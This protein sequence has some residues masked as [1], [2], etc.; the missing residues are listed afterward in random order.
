MANR[1]LINA[2]KLA[3]R[4]M[5]RA[6]QDEW[7]KSRPK[8][9]PIQSSRESLYTPRQMEVRGAVLALRE[10]RG[11]KPVMIDGP[12]GTGKT[13]GILLWIYFLMD[14]YPGIRV[15]IT[16]KTK[17]DIRDSVLVSWENHVLPPGCPMLD[18]PSRETR[19]VYRHA[20]GSEL[21]ILGLSD[22]EAVKKALSREYDIIYCS[23][24]IQLTQDQ[25]ETLVTR[26]RNSRLPIGQFLYMDC[27]PDSPMHWIWQGQLAG[28]YV[29]F[30]STHRDNPA[31]YDEDGNLTAKGK[32]YIEGQLGNLT[33]LRRERLLEGKWV[34]AE[35]A[36][37]EFDERIHTARLADMFPSRQTLP[38]E[39]TRYWVSDFG[40]THPHVWQQWAEDEDG[41]L[42]RELEIYHT[43]LL[44]RSKDPDAVTVASMIRSATKG[45][46]KPKAWICDHDRQERM[47]LEEEFGMRTTP[48]YKSVLPGI[49]AVKQNLAPA[50]DGRPR[51]CYMD[52]A[53]V[54]S[55]D[56][57]LIERKH[58]T[59][60][61]QEFAYYV[62]AESSAGKL[63]RDEPRK[64]FDHGMDATRY[65]VAYVSG[66]KEKP[67][68]TTFKPFSVGSGRPGGY[69]P[70]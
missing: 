33:G 48:A 55:P 69:V 46:P 21:S 59:S 40:T 32:Q 43:N 64:E 15:L 27:N 30:Q 22:G 36:I 39:W 7:A 11:E 8:A 65:M 50:I 38:L 53:L 42:Y 68:R 61:E 2:S 28:K 44:L 26:L 70:R 19:E 23:E 49:D 56:R 58:P 12:A 3:K 67:S 41:R 10:Y 63:G 37:Y 60:T 18:G 25:I 62:W 45:Y 5:R 14:A 47:Q 29:R 57:E 31:Y 51:I 1:F 20:N 13:I 66:L 4:K 16:R 6:Q 35:G 34:A 9:A 24:S 54:H 52:G 17:K